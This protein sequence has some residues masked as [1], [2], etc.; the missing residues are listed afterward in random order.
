MGVRTLDKRLARSSLGLPQEA[1]VVL[2]LG[3]ISVYTKLDPWPTY[4]ILEHVARQLDHP[5]VLL[6]CGPDDKPSR[7]F[8]HCIANV[9]PTCFLS[10]WAA[11]S[12]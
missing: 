9:A 10:A 12:R 7:A 5:L 11:L 4:A 3:R 2:W 6:E 1:S 8:T